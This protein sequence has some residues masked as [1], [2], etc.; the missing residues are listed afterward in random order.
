MAEIV[1]S[2]QRKN[3]E[4]GR[5]YQNPKYFDGRFPEGT[6]HVYVLGN[7]PKVIKAAEAAGIN[8]TP[9]REGA[10]ISWRDGVAPVNPDEKLVEIPDTWKHFG[11]ARIIAL[12]A[13]IAKRD[14]ANRKQAVRIIEDELDRR[15]KVDE[16]QTPTDEIESPSDEETEE[17]PDGGES[18]EEEVAPVEKSG[19]R[20]RRK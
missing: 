1:Y 20:N 11:N 2:A 8:C 15:V 7:W 16:H 9:L 4:K 3:F 12:A 14:V 19:R 13:D 17:I 5:H 18:D 10:P 6:T